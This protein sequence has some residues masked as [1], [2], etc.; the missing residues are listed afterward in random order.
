MSENSEI[1]I[2]TSKLQSGFNECRKQIETLIDSAQILYNKKKFSIALPLLILAR[3]E[4]AKLTLFLLHIVENDGITKKEW[5]EHTRGGGVHSNKLTGVVKKA[6]KR[7]ES[8]G[9]EKFKETQEFYLKKGFGTRKREYKETVTIDPHTIENLNHLN[10]IKQDCFYLDWLDGEWN[11]ITKRSNRQLKALVYTSMTSVQQLLYGHIFMNCLNRIQKDQGTDKITEEFNR[12]YEK[13]MEK[14]QE[15]YSK[16]FLGKLKIC[17][18]VL[19]EYSKKNKERT[20][21]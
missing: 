14:K 4:Y 2:P 13:W 10:T 16:K 8:A 11:I 15:L 12:Y 7:I 20:K 18:V 19:Q 17:H 3:E 21:K 9:P 6:K 5:L 1:L